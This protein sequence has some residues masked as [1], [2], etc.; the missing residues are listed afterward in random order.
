MVPRADRSAPGQRVT[1][2]MGR[3]GLVFG[4]A[5]IEGFE[6]GWSR[7]VGGAPDALFQAGSISKP[8]TALAALELAG[9]GV[10]DLEADVNDGLTSW[11]LPGPERVSLRQLLGHTSGLGVGFYPGYRQGAEAPTV[12]QSLDGIPPAATKAV[13]VRRSFYGRF[14]YSGGGYTIIQQLI[15]D[16]T[17][18]PFAEAARDLV[19][20]PLGMTS[21]TFAQPLPDD[22]RPRAARPDWRVYPEAAAAGLWTT[23][24]DLARFAAAVAAAAAGRNSAGRGA[25]DP[26]ETPTAGHGAADPAETRF[27][28]AVAAAA[29]G[30]N[31]AGRGAADPAETGAAG[32]SAVRAEAAALLVTFRTPVPFSGERLGMLAMG[33][34]LPQGYGLGMFEFGDGRFGHVGGAAS[35]FS[36]LMASQQDGGGAVIMTAANPSRFPFR[37]LRAIGEEQG[38][39]GLRASGWQRLRDL[40]ATHGSPSD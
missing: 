31:S 39:T 37:L 3:Q 14:H 4:V 11:R 28:A 9:R 18:V 2:L 38:W 36:I 6:V 17:G 34:P 32:G 35:F 16:V 13:R 1:A 23:P 21:S 26:A 33:M 25:A 27:A 29:A 24:E 19:L 8:V 7:V 12:L 20:R 22:R 10:L 15:A 40:A 5:V 30:R